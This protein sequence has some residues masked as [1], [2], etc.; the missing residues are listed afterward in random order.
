MKPAATLAAYAVVLAAA[1]GIGA[2]AG[3]AV[4]PVD[5]GG[6]S[7]PHGSAGGHAG[8]DTEPDVPAGLRTPAGL[9]VAADGYRLELVGEAPVL[10][11]PLQ[12]VISSPQGPLT[13]F[14][15]THEKRMHLVVASR[16]LQ[17]YLHVHPTMAGDGTWRVDLPALPAGAY[18]AFADFKAR[19]RDGL[20]LGIDLTV[21]GTVSSSP[22]APPSRTATVDGYTVELRGDV[23]AGAD[24][25]VELS[26]TKDG[27]PVRP[28]PYLG[29]RGHLVALRAGDLAYLH[30]HPLGDRT[31]RVPFAVEVPS[32]GTYALFFDFSH[33]GVV[34]TA[35]FVVDVP[36]SSPRTSSADAS[37][38]PASTAPSSDVHD[39][40]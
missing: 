3:A 29:A 33:N 35:R 4:G 39:D 15:V 17:T 40:H 11:G 25:D 31:D 10:P 30:V 28:D 38:R 18:R 23:A 12:F 22:Q 8:T 5:T 34:R 32:A 37:R 7:T 26:V 27:T 21:P 20:T 19:G 14:D 13:A 1:L 2:A 36:A 6:D 24:S 16:D 9:Q